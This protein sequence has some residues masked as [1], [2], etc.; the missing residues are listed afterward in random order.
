M[1]ISSTLLAVLA[2]IAGALILFD[3]ISLSLIVGVFLLAFGILTL[4]RR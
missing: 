2:M 4:I 1:K 3:R